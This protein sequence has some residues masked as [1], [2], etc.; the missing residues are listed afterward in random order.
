MNDEEFGL[1]YDKY[2]KFSASII[3]RIVKDRTE[4]DEICNDVFFRLYKLGDKLDTSDENR[5]RGLITK[6]STHCAL[7]YL[8]KAY[9][10][11]EQCT[12]DEGNGEKFTD[13][14]NIPEEKLLNMEKTTYQKLVLS[15]LRVENELSYEIIMKV[16][17]LGF[18]PDEVAEEYGM[19]RNAVNNRV[20]KKKNWLINELRKSYED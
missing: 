13:Y 1:L 4:T 19:T 10:M 12:M 8:K 2:H 17:Y 6:V 18:S 15:R 14:R 7:D 20:I 5:L 9:V 16:K 11:Y 3:Y